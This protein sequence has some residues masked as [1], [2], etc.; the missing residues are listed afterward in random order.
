MMQVSTAGLELIKSFEGLRLSPYRCSAGVPT[1][2]FGSTFYEDGARVKMGDP[3][4]T[5]ERAE[6]LLLHS[7]RGFCAGVNK[8]V[9]VPLEQP[10]FDAL[11]SFS[12]NLGLGN[13]RAS[14]LLMKLNRGEYEEI[15]EQF[16]RWNKAGGR[17]LPGL[18]RRR[19]AEAE[20]FNEG[21][22]AKEELPWLFMIFNK[23][24]VLK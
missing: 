9:R 20:L 24:K 16:L 4:I 22:E 17:A 8:S 13:L 12:Y 6:Q 7:L 11:V 14:T 18:T 10:M 15:Y 3:E 2:G 23:P 5:I 21:L 19:I 1:I